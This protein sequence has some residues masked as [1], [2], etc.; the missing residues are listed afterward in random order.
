MF[1]RAAIYTLAASLAV[2]TTPAF[3]CTGISLK[4]EDGAAIRG[5]T[6]EF[7]FPLQSNVIVVPAGKEFAG[8]LPDGGKGLTYKTR[9]DIVG[10]NAFGQAAIMDGLNDQGL[11][12]GLFYFPGYAQYAQ[13]TKENAARALAPQD[14]GMWVLGNFATVDEVK[15]A[16]KDTVMV[17]TPFP[18]LG[19]AKGMVA[20]VHF[21]VQDKSGKS[22]AVEPI[23]GKLKVTDAPLGVMTN[24]PTY[25]WH[26]TNLD[27]YINLSPKDIGSEKLGS[28]TL[29]ATGSGTGMLGLPGDFTPPSRFV[30][31]TLF[32]QAATPNAKADDAVFSAFHIL[33]QFDIPKGSVINASVGGAQ[34]EITEW[35]AVSDLKNLRWYF[36]THQDQSIRMVDLKEAIKAAKGEIR[37]IEMEKST[38]PV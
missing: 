35:T 2:A 32:S 30:R 7:G 26:M 10:A 11:S 16:L 9:Y 18:G 17:G 22:I 31:A 1:R 28:V 8:A 21:F 4:A 34:P 15:A 38:Q 27:N 3:A 13:A 12:I 36:R 14:F 19:S 20:D 5:R 24:A 37:I 25:D 23:G 6:L 33:N 29:S